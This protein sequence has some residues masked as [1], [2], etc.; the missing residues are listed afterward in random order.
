MRQSECNCAVPIPFNTNSFCGPPR[1]PIVS[2]R[3]PASEKQKEGEWGKKSSILLLIPPPSLSRSCG[4]LA[5]E[6]AETPLR[7]RGN[8][9]RLVFEYKGA[10]KICIRG[11]EPSVPPSSWRP[12]G[13]T[14]PPPPPWVP[15]TRCYFDRFTLRLRCG[16][17]EP[18][19]QVLRILLIPLSE[20]AF[21]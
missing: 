19:C 13:A 5:S 16:L 17:R 15:I 4:S 8:Y 21:N 18:A 3:S 9:M 10:Y 1:P 6:N 7:A 11:R 14:P 2:R 12:V 20:S